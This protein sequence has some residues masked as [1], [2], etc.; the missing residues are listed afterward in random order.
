VEAGEIVKRKVLNKVVLA[1]ARMREKRK[2]KG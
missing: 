2:N 1:D